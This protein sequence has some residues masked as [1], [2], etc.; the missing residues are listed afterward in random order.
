MTVV[1]AV[2]ARLSGQASAETLVSRKM[3]LAWARVEVLQPLM[4]MSVAL[5]RL[6]VGSRRRSSSVSPL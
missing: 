6:R 4:A 2:G 1:E 5:R 3:S